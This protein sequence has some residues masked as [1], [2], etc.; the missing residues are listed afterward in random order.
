MPYLDTSVLVPLI[1]REPATA[2]TQLWLSSQ[3]SGDVAIS[4]WV[5]TEVRSA[6]SIK[7]RTGAMTVKQ[8]PLA[9]ANLRTFA[10]TMQVL[11]V[12]RSAFAAAA[13]FAAAATPALRAG[14]A[15]HLAVAASQTLGLVTRDIEQGSAATAHGFRVELLA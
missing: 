13:E 12:T 1:V 2:S 9:E 5:L 7:L 4:D 11:E 14:D 8:L 15:L 10:Q 3:R 6:L